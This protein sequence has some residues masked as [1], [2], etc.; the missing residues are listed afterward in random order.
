MDDDFLEMNK[1]SKGFGENKT[2]IE[3]DILDLPLK[4]PS[5]KE[6][7]VP[8]IKFPDMPEFPKSEKI[9]ETH[10]KPEHMIKEKPHIDLQKIK[11]KKPEL[12]I[13]SYKPKIKPEKFIHV[14]K[15]HHEEA[16]RDMRPIQKKKIK[17]DYLFIRMERFREIIG[18]IDSLKENLNLEN[19]FSQKLN[20]I[21]AK[22]N[23]S[24]E[25]WHSILGELQK[26]FIFIESSIF[27][28]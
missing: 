28:R 12:H 25:K 13:P 24:L 23:R 1:E 18:D 26:K 15:I 22:R 6:K 8:E 10:H 11:A 9:I 4:L 27:K 16:Y 5:L 14:P 7:P 17:E 21:D 20:D 3:S 19:R 2:K